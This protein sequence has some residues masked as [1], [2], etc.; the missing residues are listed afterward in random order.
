M[1]NMFVATSV[2]SWRFVARSPAYN[3]TSNIS[4]CDSSFS[5]F[6]FFFL[7]SLFPCFRSL[8]LSVRFDMARE[9]VSC[10][11]FSHSFLVLLWLAT[12]RGRRYVSITC[13]HHIWIHTRACLCVCVSVAAEAKRDAKSNSRPKEWIHA[14]GDVDGAC[15]YVCEC[16]H[17]ECE[18][19]YLISLT[20]S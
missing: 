3:L 9:Y 16:Q 20:S 4:S 12:T 18:H 2:L 10:V 17:R 11:C 15:V 14:A 5:S 8:S 19:I 1:W 7:A 13:S 6:L